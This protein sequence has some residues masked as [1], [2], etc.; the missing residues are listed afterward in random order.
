MNMLYQIALA[1]C[2]AGLLSDI[3]VTI[4]SYKW[5]RSRDYFTGNAQP[6]WF[7]LSGEVVSHIIAVILWPIHLGYYRTMLKKKFP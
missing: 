3:Y 2:I 5:K 7:W 4:Q 1:W 6:F